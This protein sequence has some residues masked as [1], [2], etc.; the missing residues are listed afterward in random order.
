MVVKQFITSLQFLLYLATNNKSG[1]DTYTCCQ[2]T[3]SCLLKVET[4]HTAHAVSIQCE[5]IQLAALQRNDETVMWDEACLCTFKTELHPFL[6]LWK[7]CTLL[8]GSVKFQELRKTLQSAS[9]INPQT[10]WTV[11]GED[12]SPHEKCREILHTIQ[13]L[14]TIQLII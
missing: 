7:Q 8:N 13:R 10:T 9:T 11:K 14:L 6:H 3:S 2:Y 5:D 12:K 1:C 4:S